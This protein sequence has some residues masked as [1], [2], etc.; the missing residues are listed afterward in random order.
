MRWC[1]GKAAQHVGPKSW[2]YRSKI[3][4]WFTMTGW[5][6]KLTIVQKRVYCSVVNRDK[7]HWKNKTKHYPWLYIKNNDLEFRSRILWTFFLFALRNRGC[8]LNIP[9]SK[10]YQV[11]YRAQQREAV[12]KWVR[13]RINREVPVM[14][15]MYLWTDVWHTTLSNITSKCCSDRLIKHKN[16]AVPN[17]RSKGK[18]T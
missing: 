7:I 14:L 17:S 4:G 12:D 3:H 18:K 15:C 9:V 16:T 8:V 13:K 11:L 1:N 10:T 2:S 6:K 5:I